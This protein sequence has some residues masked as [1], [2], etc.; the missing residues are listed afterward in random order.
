MRTRNVEKGIG[1]EITM[2]L[3]ECA[4]NISGHAGYN[5]TACT[6]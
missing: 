4:I 5:D 1:T 2:R 3:T 6:Q